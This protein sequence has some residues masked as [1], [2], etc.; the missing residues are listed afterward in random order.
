MSEAPASSRR[1]NAVSGDQGL[2]ADGLRIHVGKRFPLRRRRL[3]AGEFQELA[4]RL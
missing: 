3:K 2:H 4:D 1:R